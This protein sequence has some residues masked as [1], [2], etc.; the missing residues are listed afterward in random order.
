MAIKLSQRKNKQT[1]LG[2]DNSDDDDDEDYDI[3]TNDLTEADFFDDIKVNEEDERA[4]EMF[5]N[6]AGQKSKTLAEVIME[7]IQEKQS[8]I[9]T[10]FSDCGSLKMEDIDD[11]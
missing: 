9:Q 6:K 10:Q 11:K 3:G 7:K 8:D 2:N 4:L 5:Q 1:K